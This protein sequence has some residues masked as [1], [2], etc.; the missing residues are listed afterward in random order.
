[1]VVSMTGSSGNIGYAMAF[2]IASGEMLGKDQPVILNLID[3]PQMEP[4]L[5]GVKMELEDCA[6]PLLHKVNTTS[7]M[8]V[9]FKDADCA[10][11]VGSRPR[12]KGMER[13]DLLKLNGAIFIDTGKAINDNAKRTCKTLVVGNPA[14]TNC[15]IAMKHAKDIPAENFNA[16]TRLDHNRALAN[17]AEKCDTHLS[18]IEKLIIWGNHSS[19]MYADIHNTKINGKDAL[20]L[21]GQ[22]WYEKNFIPE[23]AKRGAAIIEARGASSAASAANSAIDH[24][25][26]WV[27]GTKKWVS[28]SIPSDGTLY[29]VPKDIIY[30]FPCTVENGKAVVVKGLPL[31][32]FS[33]ERMRITSE[34]L[35]AERAEI[36]SML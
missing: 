17:L 35:L 11:L 30:S 23:V 12:T 15:L 19:T 29:G 9:G 7:N 24:M 25:R 26:D 3:I 13:G 18:N 28:M 34:E 33:K 14:N 27:L 21:V 31:S 22:E 4:K 8:S 6:F 10:M 20:S 2:R 32:D 16:M 36:E 1:M 5:K